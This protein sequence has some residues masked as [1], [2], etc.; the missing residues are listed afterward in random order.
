MDRNQMGG[1]RAGK[2]DHD[3]GWFELD[4]E[5]LRI[6]G[7]VLLEAEAGFQQT[8]QPVADDVPAEPGEPEVRLDRRD[9][10]RQPVEQGGIAE[11]FETGGALRVG[12]DAVAVEVDLHGQGELVGGLLLGSA[13][14]LPQILDPHL[15]CHRHPV[16]PLSVDDGGR[17]PSVTGTLPSFARP[18]PSRSE[19]GPTPRRRP[20]H[21]E[22]ISHRQPAGPQFLDA[23]TGGQQRGRKATHVQGPERRKAEAEVRVLAATGPAARGAVRTGLQHPAAL[24]RV[25]VT[26][27]RRRRRD[28]EHQSTRGLVAA[29]PECGCGVQDA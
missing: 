24:G 20:G 21:E 29:G 6:A 3:D 7:E 10:G 18:F 22:C 8:D 19:V 4:V 27:R 9:L 23:P 16:S 17:T 11:L 5:R 15:V 26:I 1:P 2:P 28:V 14:G 13:P 25:G 12:D